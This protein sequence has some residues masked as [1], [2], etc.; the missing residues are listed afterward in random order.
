VLGFTQRTA[1]KATALV[2][3]GS[4]AAIAMSDTRNPAM[5]EDGLCALGRL[6]SA[7]SVSALG[8]ALNAGVSD[9]HIAKI[10]VEVTKVARVA[11]KRRLE[12]EKGAMEESVEE[13]VEAAWKDAE[14]AALG[15]ASNAGVSF[16]HITKI[17]VEVTKVANAARKRRL[18]EDEKG[19]VEQAVEAAWK[20]AEEEPGGLQ[21][22]GEEI[23]VPKRRRLAWGAASQGRCVGFS[24]ER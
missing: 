24:W 16:M 2:L 20:A 4:E 11:R 14:K 5:M 18:E 9:M 23:D 7:L 8:V 13:A 12:D 21:E 17:L 22:D 10:L 3:Y 19:V 1:L 15:V 6:T